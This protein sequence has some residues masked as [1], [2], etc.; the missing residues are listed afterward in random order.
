MGEMFEWG[1]GG[2]KEGK[3]RESE[4]REGENTREKEREGVR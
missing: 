4:R 2:W 3:E 1:E